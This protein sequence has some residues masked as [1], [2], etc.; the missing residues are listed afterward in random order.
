MLIATKYMCLIF[1]CAIEFLMRSFYM[2]HLFCATIISA[3]SFAVTRSSITNVEWAII[4]T[5]SN[6]LTT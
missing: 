6:W 2:T 4:I 1:L 3:V 5:H